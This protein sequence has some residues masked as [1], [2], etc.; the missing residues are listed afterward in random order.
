MMDKKGKWLIGTILCI[1]IIILIFQSILNR[2]NIDITTSNETDKILS[3]DSIA[4]SYEDSD[5]YIYHEDELSEIEE[6]LKEC[7]GVYYT[8]ANLDNSYM[9]KMEMDYMTVGCMYS[10]MLGRMDGKA[11]WDNEDEL[12]EYLKTYEPNRTN[13]DYILNP[14]IVCHISEMDIVYEPVNA[15]EGVVW[16]FCEVCYEPELKKDTTYMEQMGKFEVLK[17]DGSWKVS[18]IEFISIGGVSGL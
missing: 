8:Y 6:M 13:N 18:Y 9:C 2:S 3:S 16:C 4:D 15:D 5:E 12:F 11:P 14:D 1:V 17:K 10:Y 7:L